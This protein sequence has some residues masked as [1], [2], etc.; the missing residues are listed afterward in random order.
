MTRRMAFV[1]VPVALG[2][3]FALPVVIPAVL[4]DKT[5][6]TPVPVSTLTAVTSGCSMF[7]DDPAT[8]PECALICT[9]P[10]QVPACSLFCEEL[11]GLR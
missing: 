2:L 5:D 6:D 8:V 11:E 3:F 7:C 9:P 1:A 10:D 4:V